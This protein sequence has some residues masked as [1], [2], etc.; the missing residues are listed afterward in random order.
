MPSRNKSII[1]TRSDHTVKRFNRASRYEAEMDYYYLSKIIHRK[2]LAGKDYSFEQD[3][4][5][6]VR[7]ALH[8]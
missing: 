7:D 1:Q 6:Q 3:Q 8:E 5:R 4:L 2:Y